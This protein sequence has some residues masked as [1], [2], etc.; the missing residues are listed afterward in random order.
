[1]QDTAVAVGQRKERRGTFSALRSANFR[2]YF[3]GQLVSQSGT[4]MQNIAQGYL[5]F[6]L[7][8]S[9]AALGV[10]A[11]MAGLPVLLMSPLA[12]VV[13]ESA[14]RKRLLI[15]TNLV[16]MMLA[17]VLTLLTVSGTVQVWHVIALAFVLGMTTAI[18][19]PSR[20]TFMVEMVGKDDLPSALAL[21]SIMNSSTRVLGP[22][23][24]GL[25]L[26]QFGM[27]WC[28]AINGLSFLVVI[29]CLVV[30]G[31][32]YALPLPKTRPNQMKQ[33]REG[34]AYVR[35][36]APVLR[37][38][39]L[40]SIAGFFLLP[41]LQML[42]A[43]AEV[44][45]HSSREGYALLSAAQGAGSVV[46]GLVVAWL[47]A[48]YSRPVIIS[49]ALVLGGVVMAVIGY[50]SNV[51]VTVACAALSGLFM[52]SV[53]VNL[54]TGIQLSLPNNFRGRVISLYMLTVFGLSPFGA[55]VLG[56][57]AEAIGTPYAL[58]V[59]GLCAVALTGLVMRRF[60]AVALA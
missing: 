41:I 60:R 43:I 2:L 13:V 39:M 17:L 12:G 27:V 46:A 5:V 8:G 9:E 6:S 35:S 3:F 50:Q 49:R 7:T 26:V 24:A 54:N 47:A 10:V 28:F 21:N 4:W 51:L 42:P 57:L 31:V 53:L 33:L 23:A 52:V 55:L 56:T 44:T 22:M 59:Y 16:Q 14:S 58:S 18:D 15:G 20:Q 19:A 48:R 32:P 45:I 38:L 29:V 30:M 36:N 25:V 37:L 11:L 40:A 34:F 1:M